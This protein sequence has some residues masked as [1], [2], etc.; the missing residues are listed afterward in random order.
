ML[1]LPPPPPPGP[2]PG[3]DKAAPLQPLLP[4]PLQEAVGGREGVLLVCAC[5]E[6]VAFQAGALEEGAATFGSHEGRV[7]RKELC[8]PPPP[9]NFDAHNPR[10]LPEAPPTHPPARLNVL[11]PPTPLHPFSGVRTECG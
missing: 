11:H 10:P 6:S 3:S 9:P 8:S 4:P 5:V 2:T 7:S 1:Q